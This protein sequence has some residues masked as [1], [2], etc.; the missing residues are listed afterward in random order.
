MAV[1]Q[2]VADALLAAAGAALVFDIERLGRADALRIGPLRR[3][4]N[5]R[6]MLVQSAR[7]LTVLSA[8]LPAPSDRAA[9]Y[10]VHMKHF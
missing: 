4:W 2:E 8:R 7:N 3:R 10:V 9:V 1:H 5:Q 6:R